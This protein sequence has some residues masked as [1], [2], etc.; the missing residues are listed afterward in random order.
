M[1]TLGFDLTVPFLYRNEMKRQLHQ[2]IDDM[3]ASEIPAYIKESK[4][5]SKSTFTLSYH[6]TSFEQLKSV[7]DFERQIRSLVSM[8]N[9]RVE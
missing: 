1:K 4:K 3:I 9:G 2:V 6:P 7:R 8:L 5:L